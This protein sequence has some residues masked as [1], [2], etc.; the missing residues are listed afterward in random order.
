[1]KMMTSDHAAPIHGFSHA[2]PTTVARMVVRNALSDASTTPNGLNR[3][4]ILM[5]FDARKTIRNTPIAAGIISV[6]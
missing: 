3:I 5:A 6:L 1:M 4:K 2:V